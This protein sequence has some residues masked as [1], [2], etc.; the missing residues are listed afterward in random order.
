MNLFNKLF[1]EKMINK[2]NLT[3][4]E[5]FISKNSSEKLKYIIS[6]S[7]YSSQENFKILEYAICNDN[8]P[9]IITA[10]L[11]RIGKFKKNELLIP[12]LKDLKKKDYIK[13]HEPYFSM[14]LLNIGIITEEEFNKTFD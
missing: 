8:N 1:K 6:I 10:S 4:L 5:V 14:L 11:K 9:E 2:K 3:N 7:N 13:N 12:L